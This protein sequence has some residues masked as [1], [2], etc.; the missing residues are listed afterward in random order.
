MKQAGAGALVCSTLGVLLLAF[1]SFGIQVSM[2]QDLTENRQV[3]L[4]HG[5]TRSA[6]SMSRMAGTLQQAGY[7]VCNIDY[8][9]TQFPIHTLATE[10][11]LPAVRECFPDPSVPLNFVTHSLGGIIVRVLAEAGALPVIG[12][13]VMLGPPNGGSEVVDKIGHLWPFQ[14]LNGPA[15]N[16]LGTGPESVPRRLGAPTFEVGVVAGSQS[17]NWILSMLIPGDDDGKV[18][19]ENAKLSGMKD[20]VVMPA[21]HPFL[22]KNRAVIRQTLHFLAHGSFQEHGK[23]P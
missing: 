14:A 18:S 9:S 16:E 8:P 10:H 17:I 13:V 19:I 3:V 11:V 20:F 15:G 22:M 12:R 1:A 21:T 6:S 5:L 4:L 23:A 2:A 7:E